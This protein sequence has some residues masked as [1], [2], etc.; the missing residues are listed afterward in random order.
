MQ[1]STYSHKPFETSMELVEDPPS[2]F[3][4]KERYSK[5]LRVRRPF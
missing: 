1:W 4:V 5:I 2:Q 3:N